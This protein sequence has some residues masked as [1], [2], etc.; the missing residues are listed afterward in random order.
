MTD[1]I[2]QTDKGKIEGYDQRGLFV[3]KGVPFAAP[4]TGKRRWQPPAPVEAWGD[5]KETKTPGPIAPQTVMPSIF[6]SADVPPEVEP[7]GEDCLYLNVWT[8]TLDSA[9][10]PVMFWIHGGGFTGGSGST[11]FYSGARL[12]ARG[13]VVVVTTNYRLGAFGFLSL[14]EVTKG[15]IPSIGNEGLLDQAAALEWVHRNIAA[16]GGNPEDVTIF[17]ESAGG[18]SVGCQLARPRTRALF[19]RAI[20]QSGAGS[21]A[22]TP[23]KATL[24]AEQ[25]L[26]ILK[27]KPTDIDALYALTPAQLLAAQPQLMGR[28]MRM[29]TGAGLAL[30]PVVDGVVISDLPVRAV[31]NGS[32]AGK[33]IIVGT[34]LDEWT[35]VNARN[36]QV[37]TLDGPG[38]EKRIRTMIPSLNAAALIE[39]YTKALARRGVPNQPCDVFT[40]IETDQKFRIPAIR[41]AEAVQK[42]GDPSFSYLFT[43]ENPGMGGKLRAHHALELGFVFGTYGP[44]LGGSGP[45]ADAV[46]RNIQDA[47]LAFAHTGNPSCESAGKW[48]VYGDRRNGSRTTMMLS[49]TCHVEE[50]PYDEERRAWESVSDEEM[51]S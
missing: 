3:F 33:P 6:V 47:W 50:A 5:V 48:P 27:V 13:D 16:F 38:L 14:N 37:Q 23:A 8:P 15:K 17:G 36:P 9:R 20:L 30:R 35:V 41:L 31:R 18:M 40:A 32:A 28:M 24:V 7:Q 39:T 1:T 44:G 45:K 46:C 19:R 25:F 11:G 22:R 21:S 26:D 51:G 12:A 10:R 49:D 2:V 43:W 4:P 29:E 34:N 42:R